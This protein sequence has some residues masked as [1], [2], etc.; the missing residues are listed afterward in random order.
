M[1]NLFLVTF[2][3]LMSCDPK[4]KKGHS[5][6][7]IEPSVSFQ[8]SDTVLQKIF[9]KAEELALKNIVDYGNRKVMIEGAGYKSVWLET[10]P[11]AGY[12][13]AKRNLTIARNNIEIFI[14]NQ[15]EDGR[16]PGV[17]YNRDGKIE[18]NYAQFQGLYLAKPAFELYFLLNKDKDYLLKVY[19]ALEKFD[20]YLWKT[21]DSDNNGCLETWC[22]YDNGEDHS[23][24]FNEF[25]NAWS[26]DY[27]PTKEIAMHLSPEELKIHCKEDHYDSTMEMIVP[28][29]SMD[30]MSYSYSCRDVLALISK[31]LQNGREPYWREQAGQVHDKLKRYLWDDEK[32]ACFDKDK[33]NETMPVLL[34]NNLRCMYFQS[35]DQNMADQFIKHHLLNPEEF[36]TPMPLP[37]I[38]ANDPMF[39]NI[40]GNNWSGQPQGLTYQRSIQALENYGHYAELTM[41]GEKFL[42]AIGDSLK[43]IQQFDPFT[44]TVNNSKDGYGPSILSALEFISRFYGIH[45]AQDKI[46]WSMLNKENDVD[47]TQQWNGNT[48]RLHTHNDVVTCFINNA[49]LFSFSKGARIVTDLNGNVIELIGLAPDLQTIELQSDQI[50]Q[51]VHLAPNEVYKEDNGELVKD[52]VIE[53]AVLKHELR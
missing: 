33:N 52:K 27:P 9:D 13:Y 25:P 42:H 32:N 50:T 24:R 46:S 17:I 38:A 53:F 6:K 8:S 11:M 2:I 21:R 35:F 18:P 49:E 7:D 1:K 51:T 12:M 5:L 40:E 3:L 29:E 14:D 39:R 19:H 44:A 30:V 22:M 15:R 41:L 43:F 37:S 34:H 28:I 36:W 23:V 16:F 10:Q 45:I 47:Y 26:F 20:T 48:Y 31:E 4:G